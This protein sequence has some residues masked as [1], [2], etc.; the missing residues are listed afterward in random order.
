[1][2]QLLGQSAC[3]CLDAAMLQPRSLR[4]YF[5][6][7]RMVGTICSAIEVYP[8]VPSPGPAVLVSQQR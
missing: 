3:V 7:R 1:M 4:P 8:L 6:S 2:A 5:D